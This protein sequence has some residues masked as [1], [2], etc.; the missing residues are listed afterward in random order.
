MARTRRS[1]L[2]W[3]GCEMSKFYAL[4]NIQG[5]IVVTDEEPGE[6]Q[7]ALAVG[8]FYEVVRVIFETSDGDGTAVVPGVVEG[9]ADRDN[10]S[11]IARYIQVLDKHNAPGFRAL[12][13]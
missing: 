7:F 11:A 4:C 10:L 13:A 6:G 8:A 5:Q 9:A 1:F 3:R 12:G 2:T